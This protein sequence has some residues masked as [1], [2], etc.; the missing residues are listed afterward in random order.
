MRRALADLADEELLHSL[1]FLG[2]TPQSAR[3]GG[4]LGMQAPP[5]SGGAVVRIN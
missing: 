2:L 5:K 4:V 3:R 1:S